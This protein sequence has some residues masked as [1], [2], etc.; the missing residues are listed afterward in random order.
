M[1][2]EWVKDGHTGELFIV[3]ARPSGLTAFELLALCAVCATMTSAEAV[4]PP[5]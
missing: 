2:M 5:G 3:Q 4:E 1:D